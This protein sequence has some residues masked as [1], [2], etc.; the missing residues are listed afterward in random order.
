MPRP[1]PQPSTNAAFFIDFDG[2]LVQIAS[3]PELVEVE[4]RARELLE[5]LRDRYD[6]A[7]AIVTGRSLATI[8]S[9]LAP[10]VLP[11]AAEHGSVRRDATGRIHENASAGKAV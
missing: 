11:I 7:V 8:D 5:G 4:P 6:N 2:T 1:L 10:L 9:F 3:R